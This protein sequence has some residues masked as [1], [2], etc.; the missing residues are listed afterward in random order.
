[1]EGERQAVPLLKGDHQTAVHGEHIDMANEFNQ[2]WSPDKD[3]RAHTT[4]G[5]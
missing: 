5:T 1:M 2:L 3:S 4:N